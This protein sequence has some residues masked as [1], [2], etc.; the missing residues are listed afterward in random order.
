MHH[1][2][3]LHDVVL[4]FQPELA[5]IARARFAVAGNIIVIGNGF[6]AD[7]T[8]LEIGVDHAS[9]LR[10]FRSPRHRPGACFFRADREESDETQKI[11]TRADQ[12]IEARLLQSHGGEEFG[13]FFR[14]KLRD[15]FFDA[16]RDDDAARTLLLRHLFHGLGEF[17]AGGGGAFFDIAD[18]EYRLLRQQ[19]QLAERLA[20][21]RC[22]VRFARGLSVT[23]QHQRLHHQRV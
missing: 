17:V 20:L 19:A 14:R 22:E 3:I 23:Q 5:R 16:G 6:G 2:A 9:A 11:V 8:M 7:E 4:A 1:V 15:F 18:I 21:F 10:R 13:A 12:A